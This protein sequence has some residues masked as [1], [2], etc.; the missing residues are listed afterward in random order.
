MG[1]C[2][3]RIMWVSGVAT[4]SLHLISGQDHSI[5]EYYDRYW[6]WSLDS[7]E[8]STWAE[9]PVFSTTAGFGG[10]GTIPSLS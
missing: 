10:N 2:V 3:E 1:G 4:V 9:S 8:G 5:K 6:D 7:K